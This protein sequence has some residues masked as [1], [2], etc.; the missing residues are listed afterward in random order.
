V[1]YVGSTDG[2][3]E[4]HNQNFRFAEQELAGM[5]IFFGKG[6]C[7]S[8]HTPPA[9]SDYRF[10]NTGISQSDYDARHGQGAFMQLVVPDSK[11]RSENPELGKQYKN[12]AKKDKPGYTDL[13][14][15]NILGNP[16]TSVAHQQRLRKR[17]CG[18]ACPAAMA[19]EKS[20]AAFKT[21]LLR[22]LGH[23]APYMHDGSKA[24]LEDVLTH[25]LQISNLARNGK[26]RNSSA[27]VEAIDL[28]AGDIKPLAAFLRALNE[29]YE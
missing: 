28:T 11:A 20:L 19:I 4:L 8:C 22:D 7:I 15:W 2:K 16:D 3:L 13:G 10:H 21:P 5:R 26:L 14:I 25:Y 27:D 6:N 18:D 17:L 23:N 9:F 29:D 12:I 1:A 24:T